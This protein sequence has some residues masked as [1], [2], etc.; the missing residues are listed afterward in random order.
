[1]SNHYNAY[2]ACKASSLMALENINRR[3]RRKYTQK[4]SEME[5]L[6]RCGSTA[7]SHGDILLEKIFGC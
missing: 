1:M 4:Y 7:Q 3:D 6:P 5:S 2:N